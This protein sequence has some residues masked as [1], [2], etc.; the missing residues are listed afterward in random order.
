MKEVAIWVWIRWIKWIL[1]V[2]YLHQG[3]GEQEGLSDGDPTHDL[4]RRGDVPPSRLAHD[5]LRYC[6]APRRGAVVANVVGSTA[7]LMQATGDGLA[8]V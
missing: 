1:W 6:R 2:I 8:A 3:E 7:S 5:H 4:S